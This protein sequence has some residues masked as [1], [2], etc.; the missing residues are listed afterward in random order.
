M[1]G[2]KA[3]GAQSWPVFCLI[4][5]TTSFSSCRAEG[6]E[7]VHITAAYGRVIVALQKESGSHLMHANSQSQHA[8]ES[9]RRHSERA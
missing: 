7:H 2:C 5:D 6:P 1:W 8:S 3:S 4:L 9:S